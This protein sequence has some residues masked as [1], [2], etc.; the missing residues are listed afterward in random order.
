MKKCAKCERPLLDG[1]KDLCPA[2][3]SDGNHEAKRWTEIIVGTVAVVA[4]ILVGVFSGGKG[5]GGGSA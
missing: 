4:V 1:E 2:C 3:I 5:S